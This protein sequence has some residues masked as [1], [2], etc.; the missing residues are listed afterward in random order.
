MRNNGVYRIDHGTGDCEYLVAL[1]NDEGDNVIYSYILANAVPIPGAGFTY[2][3]SE[4]WV[5]VERD[6]NTLFAS[7][8]DGRRYEGRT[9]DALVDTGLLAI[10]PGE[11]EK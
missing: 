10:E 6:S 8:E 3:D 5:F 1:E 9:V 11:R 4:F 2:D 7:Y